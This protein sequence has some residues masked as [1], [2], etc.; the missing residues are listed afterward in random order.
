M[1]CLICCFSVSV[2]LHITTTAWVFVVEKNCAVIQGFSCLSAHHQSSQISPFWFSWSLCHHHW[3]APLDSTESSR[4]PWA[5]QQSECKHKP[6]Y[7][8][9]YIYRLSGLRRVPHTVSSWNAAR[10]PI[11]FIIYLCLIMIPECLSQ[12]FYFFFHSTLFQ[13]ISCFQIIVSSI[14]RLHQN[15]ILHNPVSLTPIRMTQC[16]NKNRL[17]KTAKN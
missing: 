2:S 8:Y 16:V 12:W 14:N 11:S 1:Q 9:I 10:D 15:V 13:C 5:V 6:I 17:K 4:C 3:V 7:I